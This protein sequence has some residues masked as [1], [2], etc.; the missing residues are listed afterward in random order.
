MNMS[1]GGVAGSST[2]TSAAQY[3]RSKGAVVVAAAGNCGCDDPTPENP[4]LIS[5][6]ATTSTDALASFSSR[7]AFVDVAA[8]GSGIYTTAKG[9][10][11][12][13]VSG[14]SFSSPITAGVVAL[15]MAANPTLTPAAVEQILLSTADDLGPAGRDTSFGYGLVNAWQAV[16]AAGSSPLPPPDTSPPVVAITSPADGAG[17]TGSI[18]VSASASDN[19]GVSKVELYLDGVL[20]AADALAP[21]TFTWDTTKSSDGVHTLTARAYD[22]A[23]NQAASNPVRVTVSNVAADT[24]PPAVAITAPSSGDTVT[25]VAKVTVQASDNNLVSAVDILIDGKLVQTTATN[26]SAVTVS[27]S[28]NTRKDGAGPHTLSA[29]A[30]DAA[31]NRSVSSPVAVTVK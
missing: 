25:K 20:F 30:R 31:G 3:A 1:F 8:P 18:T 15:I 4:Y 2:I 16:K 7:G 11:Y 10:G 6:S 26:A 19:I 23:G 13:S 17:V 21:Y 5:V 14:T 29:A 27:Y 12:A 24:T 9:G 22:A 28:W